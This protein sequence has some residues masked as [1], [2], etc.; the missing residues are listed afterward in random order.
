MA[1]PSPILVDMD[2]PLKGFEGIK[3]F[4]DKSN[5]TTTARI[6]PGEYYVTNRDEMITTVLG[7]CVSACICDPRT[8]VGGM[9]HFMLPSGTTLD[10]VYE[11][12]CV[13]RS[14]RYGNFA[15]EHL[16]NTI[17]KHGGRKTSLEIKIIG[18]G[19]IIANMSNIGLQNIDFVKQ[20]LATE[21]FAIVAEDVGDKYPRKLQYFPMTGKVRVQRL[22]S[23]HN[24][25]VMDREKEYASNIDNESVKGEIDLF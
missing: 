16:I 15:M 10:N 5:N 3:R 19:R 24:R 20:Y 22:K 2:K 21:G 18:G 12:D 1:S 11:A 23:M 8:K 13:S 6:L 25:T 4:C 14:A 7:S 9:N 17:L